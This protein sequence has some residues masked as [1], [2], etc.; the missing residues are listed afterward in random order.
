M[1]LTGLEIEFL[2]RLS[3]DAWV[4]PPLFDRSLVERLVEQG[5]IRAESLPTGEVRYEIT[6][7]GSDGILED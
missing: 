6:E 5:Y 7:L 4:S 3:R 1:E 2:K